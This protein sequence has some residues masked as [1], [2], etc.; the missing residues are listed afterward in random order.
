MKRSSLIRAAV[1]R[2]C[3]P[4]PI[5]ESARLKLFYNITKMLLF[6]HSVDICTDD[7]KAMMGKTAGALHESGQW[8][9]TVPAVIVFFI[10]MHSQKKKPIT[11]KSALDEAVKI[12]D[13]IQF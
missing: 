5:Q 7:M 11:L 10:V 8:Y 12:T 3:F 13:F 2:M 6:P 1:L 9:Q 4:R